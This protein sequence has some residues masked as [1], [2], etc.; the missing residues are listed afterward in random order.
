VS[1]SSEVDELYRL[2]QQE[3]QQLEQLEQDC[4]AQEAELEDSDNSS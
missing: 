2:E 1:T 3:I 4:I